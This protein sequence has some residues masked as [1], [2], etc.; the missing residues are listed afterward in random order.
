MT[1]TDTT[2]PARIAI[3]A[4]EASGDRLGAGLAE[5]IAARR[6]DVELVGMGGPRMAGAGVRIVQDSRVVSVVGI[7]EVL[8][9]LPA[10]RG[11]MSRLE[12][13]LAEERPDLLVPIDF[14][15]FN[16]RLARRAAGA[17]VPVVYFVSPQIWA[18]RRGRVRT[19]A[20]LVRRML[21]LFP[22]ETEFYR[23]AGV[24]A[25]FVGHPL[26]E[27]AIDPPSRA[28]LCA[29]IGLDADRPVVALLPG[30]RAG[31]ARR[32]APVLFAAAARLQADRAELQ[33]L[34]P[35]ASGLSEELFRPF[36]DA[37][38]VRD[39]RLYADEF[40][41]CLSVC[42]AGVVTAGTASLEAASVGL[43]MVVVYRMSP[44]SYA[45]GRLLVRV[46]HVAMPNLIAGRRVVPEL[47][48]GECTPAAVSAAVAA[49]LDDPAHAERTRRALREVRDRLGGPGVFER[50]ADEVLAELDAA[51]PPGPV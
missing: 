50:A 10:I 36:I 22:F 29:R 35:T 18:W 6:P 24:H 11:A 14:P 16:M 31:E 43:P 27:R 12:R 39:V 23:D 42:A 1:P 8:S 44:L 3:S 19:I 25:V 33:F 37:H 34:V 49:Y 48:Q 30:S 46:E 26:A 15:D 7:V 32:M 51:R 28:E 21:V 45:L 13:M 41:E 40:P 47:I 20:R 4:G 38:G 2:R 5:A 9:H 17:G